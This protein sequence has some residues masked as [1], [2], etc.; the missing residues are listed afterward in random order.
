[1]TAVGAAR[2]REAL[3]MNIAHVHCTGCNTER[4]D[5]SSGIRH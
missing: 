1:M 2:N 3:E 4:L 5:N